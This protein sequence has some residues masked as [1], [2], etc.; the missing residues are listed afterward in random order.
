METTGGGIA[1]LLGNRVD[2]ANCRQQSCILDQRPSRRLH[3]MYG[4]KMGMSTGKLVEMAGQL[5]GHAED[6]THTM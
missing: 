5:N 1:I 4:T 6:F 3:A 2:P